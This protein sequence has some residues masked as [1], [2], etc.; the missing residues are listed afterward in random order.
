MSLAEKTKTVITALTDLIDNC[1]E[2]ELHFHPS[3]DSWNILE[4]AEHIWLVN[5]TIYRFLQTPPPALPHQNKESELHS[6]GK[7]NHLLIT[8]RDTKRTAP[9]WVIPKGLFKTGEEAKQAVHKATSDIRSILETTDISRETHTLAHPA[10]GEM[11]KTDWVH[12]LISHT[13][14]HVFQMQE[15]KEK[16]HS[17][18]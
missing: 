1:S 8:K 11:T 3:A 13:Q 4:C 2:E 18:V 16:F 12:F 14:R 17:V 6:E 10:I 7:M 15:I 5:A 9:Q